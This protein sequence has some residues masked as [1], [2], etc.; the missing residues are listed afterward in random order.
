V[1]SETRSISSLADQIVSTAS[2]KRKAATR[3]IYIIQTKAAH[4]LGNGWYSA[5]KHGPN[6][7]STCRSFEAISTSTST[8]IIARVAGMDETGVCRK[9]MLHASPKDSLSETDELREIW[10]TR[11]QKLTI[12]FE[13]VEISHD[14]TDHNLDRLAHNLSS[15]IAFVGKLRSLKEIT[16]EVEP[17]FTALLSIDIEISSLMTQLFSILKV[18]N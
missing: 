14:E 3:D 16:I 10:Y 5:E 4:Q 15:V 13:K 7:A 11:L 9:G 6:P 1:R 12:R 18:L 17:D 8:T 2:A